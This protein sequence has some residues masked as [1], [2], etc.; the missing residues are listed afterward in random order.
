MVDVVS[1]CA[2]KIR[3]LS[4]TAQPQPLSA[5]ATLILGQNPGFK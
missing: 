2:A 5:S 4:A 1:E 3:K